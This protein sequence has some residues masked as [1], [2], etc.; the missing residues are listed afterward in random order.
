MDPIY[1]PYVELFFMFIGGALLMILVPWLIIERIVALVVW[2][3][4]K[5]RERKMAYAGKTGQNVPSSRDTGS[6]FWGS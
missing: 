1:W 3:K 4:R 5:R 6:D 2:I